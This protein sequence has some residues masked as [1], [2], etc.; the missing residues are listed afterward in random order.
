VHG[1]ECICARSAQQKEGTGKLEN[2]RRKKRGVAWP[3]SASGK[4][5]HVILVL[6]LALRTIMLCAK[7]MDV[8]FQSSLLG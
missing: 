2:G 5:I 1:K 3:L 6:P 4:E 7:K 8:A